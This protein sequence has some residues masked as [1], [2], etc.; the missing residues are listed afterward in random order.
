MFAVDRCS[1]EDRPGVLPIVAN[2]FQQPE[3]S[4]S[5]P[6]ADPGVLNTNYEALLPVHHTTCLGDIHAHAK[7]T[8]WAGKMTLCPADNDSMAR[9]I[10]LDVLGTHAI[11]PVALIGTNKLKPRAAVNSSFGRWHTRR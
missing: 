3:Y 10:G 7:L 2:W 11:A 1:P 8:R 5:F 4:L 6:C 9:R